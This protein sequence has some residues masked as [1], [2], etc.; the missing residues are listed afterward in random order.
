MRG[1]G[2]RRRDSCTP[3][4]VPGYK[5]GGTAAGRITEEMIQELRLGGPRPGRKGWDS[6]SQI[7]PA[8]GWEDTDT[9]GQTEEGD[10]IMD[11]E[12]DRHRGKG[13]KGKILVYR[14]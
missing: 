14:D 10:E 9:A 8:A 4:S 13:G 6:D 5:D 1:R 11:T 3:Y 7:Q 2:G 12:P